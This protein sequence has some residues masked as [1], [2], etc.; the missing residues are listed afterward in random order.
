MSD[1]WLFGWGVGY[2]AVGAASLLVPLYALALSGGPALVGILAATAA[3][4]GVPG[5]LIWGR[6]AARVERRR[7]FVLVALGATTLVLAAM[8]LVASPWLLVGVNAALW[9]VV[10]AAAP[11]LNLIV[12]DEYP[13]SRWTD[14]IGRLNAAQGYGWVAGL[15]LG[16]VWTALVSRMSALSGTA[17]LR[18]LFGLLAGVA[19][20]GFV[21]V[22]V[23]Y[24]DPTTIRESL[25][26]R[27]YR[28]LAWET[29]GSGRF[30][31]TVPFGPSRVYWSLVTL[32]ADRV[33]AALDVPLRR[34]LLATACFSTGFAVFW[35]PMPAFLT[36]GGLDTGTVF[37]LFLAG[38]VGSASTYAR[39]ARL[40][41]RV[42]EPRAQ[43]GALLARVVL[44][45]AVGVVGA[46]AF[47]AP[48]VALGFLL[49]GVTW[50]VIAVTT[51]SFVTRLAPANER[52]EALGLQT[53]L[54]GGATGVG[55]ALGGLLAGAVGYQSTFLAAGLLVLLG[56]VVVLV[57][58]PD[59]SPAPSPAD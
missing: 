26:R 54:A 7:P 14:R 32:R 19:A 46:T 24:P 36:A 3:F 44:F 8:P 25:F 31:R 16:T 9:F 10:S 51:T 57:A 56:A 40:V 35:G 17:S 22:R 4:A 45:P 53:A 33:R 23:W 6:L 42:G 21:V 47:A 1:R 50:G 41:E 20:L 34:Y 59:A 11:V 29:L 2:A 49:I 30:L 12:V 58:V 15:L 55:S 52:G 38:N 43:T 28:K 27:R 37:A 5:A 48:G 13:T 39:V 18:L